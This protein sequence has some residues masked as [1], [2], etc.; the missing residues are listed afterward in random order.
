LKSVAYQPEPFNWNPAADSSFLNF[1][2][3][4]L[5]HLA[6]GGS[7]TFWRNSSWCPQTSQRYS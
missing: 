1:F 6:I 4:Q 2:L 7:D 3:P 5:G